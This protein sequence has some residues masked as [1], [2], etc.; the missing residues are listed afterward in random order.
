MIKPVAISIGG[1]ESKIPNRIRAVIDIIHIEGTEI[2]N[3]MKCPRP[4]MIIVIRKFAGGRGMQMARRMAESR[5]NPPIL[6]PISWSY[7]IDEISQSPL[8][9]KWDAYFM[10]KFGPAEKASTAL[11]IAEPHELSDAPKASTMTLKEMW[12]AY[13]RLLADAVRAVFKPGEKMD[14][15]EFLPIVAEEVGLNEDQVKELLPFLAI[16]GVIDNPVGDTWR[17]IGAEGFTV[18]LEPAEKPKE[19]PESRTNQILAAMKGLNP[20]PYPSRYAIESAMMTFKEFTGKDGS[21]IRRPQ[22]YKYVKKAESIGIVYEKDGDYYVQHNDELTLTPLPPPAEPVRKKPEV[23]EVKEPPVEAKPQP[24]KTELRVSDDVKFLRDM[25]GK[26]EKPNLEWAVVLGVKSI[27]PVAHWDKLAEN[28][29]F[30]ILR[31]KSVSPRPIPKPMFSPDEWDSLA[32]DSIKEF[33]IATMAPYF[34]ISYF[35]EQI[36]CIDC[37]D[38]F[39]FTA[40]EKL[41]FFD[42][43]LTPPKRCSSC[44]QKKGAPPSQ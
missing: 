26:V 27:M 40:K 31:K 20:G 41:F 37:K 11:S 28:S 33:T 21:A 9:G 19:E 3:T 17:L 32:W 5:G 36:L 7:V 8:M 10:E 14:L 16:S 18:D 25:V 6:T 22:A 44:R 43:E 39:T 29:I 15:T 1:L 13:E 12:E 23:R 35:D 2:P 42:R 24:A 34:T 30:K 38:L 4:D